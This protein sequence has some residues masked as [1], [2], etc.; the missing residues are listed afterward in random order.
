M[1]NVLSGRKVHQLVL[2]FQSRGTVGNMQTNTL[3]PSQK[4][5]I[6]VILPSTAVTLNASEIFSYDKFT[7][8]FTFCCCL[9]IFK[10]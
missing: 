6:I 10:H 8:K 1:L 9:I 2:L 5:H 4:T 3:T 7:I